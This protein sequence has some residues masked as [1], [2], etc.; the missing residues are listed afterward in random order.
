[1]G[2]NLKGWR[3]VP[4]PSARLWL[5]VGGLRQSPKIEPAR[6]AACLDDLADAEASFS[7]LAHKVYKINQ[8]L[9]LINTIFT[10]FAHTR[11]VFPLG[12]C[13][14]YFQ[15]TSIPVSFMKP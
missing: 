14:S 2:L 10:Q 3:F 12:C 1:M 11:Q 8:A 6:S 7:A 13:Q 15:K 9:R 5:S 4:Q